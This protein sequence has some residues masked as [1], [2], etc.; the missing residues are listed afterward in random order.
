MKQGWNEDGKM[1]EGDC[2]KGGEDRRG[3]ERRYK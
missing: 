1:H 3:M 2:K